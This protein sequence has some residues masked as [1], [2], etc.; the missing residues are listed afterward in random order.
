MCRFRLVVLRNHQ[1][2]V[3]RALGR[4][5]IAHLSPSKIDADS[6]LLEPINVEEE[7]QRCDRALARIHE[8]RRALNLPAGTGQTKSGPNNWEGI[9]TALR[10]QEERLA[11]LRARQQEAR[12]RADQGRSL[13][14]QLGPFSSLHA[15]LAETRHSSFAHFVT[16]NLLEEE[17]EALRRRIGEDAFLWS[18]PSRVGRRSVMIVTPRR[19]REA[20]DG[21]LK[22]TSFKAEP[23]PD[24]EGKTTESLWR[25]S[26]EA[27]NDAA[28]ALARWEAE[29]AALARNLEPRLDAME[30]AVLAER[31]LVLATALFARTHTTVLMTGWVPDPNQLEFERAVTRETGGIHVL[32][33]AG[34]EGV[35]TSE[36][37]V[38]LQDP[39]FFRPFARLVTA[40]GLP[41][42]GEWAPT[43]W[44]ALTYPV[45]FGIAR[46]QT[47][48]CKN[49]RAL[50]EP[51]PGGTRESNRGQARYERGPRNKTGL[52]RHGTRALS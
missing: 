33:F 15:P 8:L 24:V 27:A 50:A 34:T 41:R 32:Q 9:E 16:G 5:G 26:R 42:Y 13:F 7:R 6:S 2:G 20:L 38:L 14:T 11:V 51:G 1:R 37:P 48:P 44:V 52:R 35:P 49:G 23:L 17:L 22:Q 18:T 36:I 43:L 30:T 28:S 46:M 47:N 3:L 25:E 29:E 45:L 21:A 39:P 19:R 31:D 12:N 10:R 4:L 40:Y